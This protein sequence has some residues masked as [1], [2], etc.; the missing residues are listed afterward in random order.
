MA[1]FKTASVISGIMTR[2]LDETTPLSHTAG[3]HNAGV[4]RQFSD[5]VSGSTYQNKR[6]PNVREARRYRILCCL[7]FRPRTRSVPRERAGTKRNWAEACEAA[8]IKDADELL[9]FDENTRLLSAPRRCLAAAFSTVGGCKQAPGKSTAQFQIVMIRRSASV[10]EIAATPSS[11]S[12]IAK[13]TA[14]AVLSATSI[15][16]VSAWPTRSVSFSTSAIRVDPSFR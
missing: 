12:A 4:I 9:R 13:R 3:L 10:W 14:S 2:L 1:R 8:S 7:A 5:P 6:F 15:R 11:T 16:S